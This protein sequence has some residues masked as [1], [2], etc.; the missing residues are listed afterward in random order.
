MTFR[1]YVELIIL[2][3]FYFLLVEFPTQNNVSTKSISKFTSTPFLATLLSYLSE[4]AHREIAYRAI[5]YQEMAGRESRALD[6]MT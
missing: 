2:A 5:P 1:N 4:G 3:R 6:L